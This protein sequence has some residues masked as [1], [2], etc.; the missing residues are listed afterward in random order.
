MTD[1]T[2]GDPEQS[3][4]NGETFT[5]SGSQVITPGA[6]FSIGIDTG[7]SPV[8]IERRAYSCDGTGLTVGFFEGT[9]QTGGTVVAGVNRNRT[10]RAL[11]QPEPLT[12][13]TG[14]TPGTLNAAVMSLALG[15]KVALAAIFGD[16][17]EDVLILADSSRYVLQ[18][19]NTGT[20][21]TTLN[22][23]WRARRVAR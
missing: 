9:A 18:F 22:W 4:V 16:G 8:M 14:V 15:I 5:Y 20:A 7:V 1:I 3:V 10:S 13:R 19:T 2:R 21:S 12:L 23:S 6:S 11:S 17:A